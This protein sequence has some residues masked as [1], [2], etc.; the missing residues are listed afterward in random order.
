M[1]LQRMWVHGNSVVPE[2]TIKAEPFGTDG[3][4][5]DIPDVP[6]SGMLGYRR[7]DGTRYRGKDGQFNWFHF[8]IPSP[9]AVQAGES[10]KLSKVFVLF[11]SDPAVS[12]AAI[13]VWDGTRRLEP[14]P[15][16]PG[17]EGLTHASGN[18][19]DQLLE[20][21]TMWTFPVQ[22]LIAR[23]I[24]ISAGVKFNDEGEI[25]FYSAGA[26]FDVLLGR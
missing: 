10:V 16:R 26:E 4:L 6:G 20:N 12:I 14:Q 18:P 25:R 9:S 3:P 5:T 7:G 19:N 13:H 8:S 2:R 15:G 24:V 1:P 11:V 17:F 23:G 22:Q 21:I